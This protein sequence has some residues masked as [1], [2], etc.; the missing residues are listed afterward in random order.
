MELYKKACTACRGG[1]PPLAGEKAEALNTNVP[2]WELKDDATRLVRQFRFN[3]YAE[4]LAFVNAI[5]AVAESERHH[6]D[7]CFGWGYVA[8]TLWTHKIRGLHENDF[9]LAAKF[10][11]VFERPSA[12]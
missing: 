4:S 10:D 5:S 12:G 9:I 2:Q 7:V 3:D 6:P 8:I 1:V 11:R